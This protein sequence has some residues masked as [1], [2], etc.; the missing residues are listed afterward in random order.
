MPIKVMWVLPRGGRERTTT[1]RGGGGGGGVQD[2]AAKGGEG[3]G[4][5]DVR[6]YL[7][8]VGGGTEKKS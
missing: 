4:M 8:N 7:A 3:Q 5:G 6:T 1:R 2:G